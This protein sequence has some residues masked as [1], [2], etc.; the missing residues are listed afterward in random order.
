MMKLGKRTK[1]KLRELAAPAE[2]AL[3]NLT[4]F[5]ADLQAAK[6][7]PDE[8]LAATG[9]DGYRAAFIVDV[10]HRALY[11]RGTPEGA[12]LEFHGKVT[13]EGIVAALEGTLPDF[14]SPLTRP[15]LGG[16]GLPRGRPRGRPPGRT[17]E[18]HVR[19]WTVECLREL[20]GIRSVAEALRLWNRW[21]PEHAVSE[22]KL[23]STGRRTFHRDLNVVADDLKQ[24]EEARRRLPRKRG[25]PRK[26]TLLDDPFFRS[27][28]AGKS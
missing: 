7:K 24:Y 3:G 22:S 1:R 19:V 5:G 4:A 8:R 15:V 16:L 12:A 10:A 26:D 27:L 13:W 21:F 14:A 6:T 25:R 23:E 9:A 2:S 11:I 28:L 20:A 17:V 18:V